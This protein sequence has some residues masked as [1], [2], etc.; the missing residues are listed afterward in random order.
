MVDS[1]EISEQ[2]RI[3]IRLCIGQQGRFERSE[4][5]CRG[6]FRHENWTEPF[7]GL[8]YARLEIKACRRVFGRQ[9]WREAF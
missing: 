2:P 4:H 3:V 5:L 9:H 1:V 8:R 6:E 7:R